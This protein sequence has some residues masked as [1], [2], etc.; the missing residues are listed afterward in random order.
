V[1]LLDR[2]PLDGAE[3]DHRQARRR[4]KGK[5]ASPYS[6]GYDPDPGSWLAQPPSVTLPTI[7]PERHK[8]AFK[9]AMDRTET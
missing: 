6:P 9:A 3:P 7:N 1:T 4:G 5:G 2:P 8:A